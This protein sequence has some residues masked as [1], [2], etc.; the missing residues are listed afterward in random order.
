VRQQLLNFV[1]ENPA[2]NAARLIYADWLEENGHRGDQLHGELIRVQIELAGGAASSERRRVLRARSREIILAVGRDL[3][4]GCEPLF[5]LKDTSRDVPGR[6]FGDELRCTHSH[7][8]AHAAYL[9]S[10]HPIGKVT[11]IDRSPTTY[12]YGRCCWLT[13]HTFRRRETTVHDLLYGHLTKDEEGIPLYA[14]KGL[15]LDDLSRACVTCGRQMAQ[16]VCQP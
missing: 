3:L 15:A 5:H 12:P 7:F 6:G 11:L 1:L 8:F 4:G 2:D 9:F 13:E 16:S 14:S 10:H